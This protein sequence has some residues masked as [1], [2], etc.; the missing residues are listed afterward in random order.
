MINEDAHFRHLVHDFLSITKCP[1]RASARTTPL[2]LHSNDRDP[3]FMQKRPSGHVIESRLRPKIHVRSRR[4]AHIS[5]NDAPGKKSCDHHT[6]KE[7]WYIFGRTH[8]QCKSP[9][10]FR[11]SLHISAATTY[12]S[13][14]LMLHDYPTQKPPGGSLRSRKKKHGP[15]STRLNTWTL[16]ALSAPPISTLR[17]FSLIFH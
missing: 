1:S 17:N 10:E 12:R 14:S 16:C 13:R 4:C 3:L 5:R 7:N 8:K 11:H 2:Y 9:C 15:H 6:K